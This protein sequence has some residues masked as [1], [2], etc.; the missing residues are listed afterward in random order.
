MVFNPARTVSRSTTALSTKSGLSVFSS[1]CFENAATSSI[2]TS[3]NT[4]VAVVV[5]NVVRSART[6]STEQIFL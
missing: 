1:L 6:M 2:A 4:F 5:D 3:K